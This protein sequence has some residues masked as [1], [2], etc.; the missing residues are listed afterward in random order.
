MPGRGMRH[1]RPRAR[2]QG[3]PLDRPVKHRRGP[4]RH[5]AQVHH[6]QQRA[7]TFANPEPADRL[8]KTP[9]VELCETLLPN[10]HSN[11]QLI[12]PRWTRC[13]HTGDL[14]GVEVA[15]S[16]TRTCA[17]D[18]LNVDAH[19]LLVNSDRHQITRV[20]HAK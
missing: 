5:T 18:P 1:A 17:P 14:G 19:R 13:S 10:P 7:D 15:F 2:R 16:K 3:K 20:R 12:A 9:P 4:N 11:E 8:A 6:R